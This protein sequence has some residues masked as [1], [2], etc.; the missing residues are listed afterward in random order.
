MEFGPR[1]EGCVW[2]TLNFQGCRGERR[3]LHAPGRGDGTKGLEL[4]A[5]LIVVHRVCQ[6]LDV[7]VHALVLG[8]ALLSDVIEPREPKNFES[9]ERLGDRRQ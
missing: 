8:H 2:C 3:H 5:Q 7:E 1:T 6:V 9:W 4:G